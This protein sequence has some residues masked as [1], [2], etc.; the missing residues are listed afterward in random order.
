MRKKKNRHAITKKAAQK[1]HAMRR[2][3]ERH[4]IFL[5]KDAQREI[6]G[7]IRAGKAK[8]LGRQSLRVRGYEIEHAGKLLTVLYD[9]KRKVLIT[10]LPEGAI[11]KY[12]QGAQLSV[13]ETHVEVGGDIPVLGLHGGAGG[14][15]CEGPPVQAMLG[16]GAGQA[17]ES[18]AAPAAA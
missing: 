1:I 12:A 7:R 14:A 2:A 4:G 3:Y 15:Q 18:H 8:L 17:C 5:G 13:P 6:V 10:V 11:W 16:A 9:K